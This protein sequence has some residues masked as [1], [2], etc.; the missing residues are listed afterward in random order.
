[1]AQAGGIADLD[2]AAGHAVAALSAADRATIDAAD[3]VAKAWI[4][5]AVNEQLAAAPFRADPVTFAEDMQQLLLRSW[6]LAAR[7]GH[8]QVVTEHLFVALGTAGNSTLEADL[9]SM[10]GSSGAAVVAGSLVSISSL[11]DYRPDQTIDGLEASENIVRWIKEAS[12]ITGA[13]GSRPGELSAKHLVDALGSNTCDLNLRRLLRKLLREAARVG[14]PQSELVK[15]RQGLETLGQTTSR[16]RTDTKR[17][18]KLMTRRLRQYNA[19]LVEI[20]RAADKNIEERLSAVAPQVAAL[21]TTLTE[22]TARLEGID[23][24]MTGL[25]TTRLSDMA[26]AL[27]PLQGVPAKLDMLVERSGKPAPPPGP[28]GTP[29]VDSGTITRLEQ[30]VAQLTV[31]MPQAPKPYRLALAVAAVIGLGAAAGL[32]LSPD[33]PGWLRQMATMDILR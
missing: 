20:A 13:D 31:R 29:G 15:A 27:A 17:T 7:L 33:G 24:R 10:G 26:T 4:C 28:G 5:A 11:S 12:G 3:A 2:V 16:Y 18:T 8:R 6:S 19:R 23:G 22:H 21:G 25:A 32:A 30:R 14:H 1:M 9:G